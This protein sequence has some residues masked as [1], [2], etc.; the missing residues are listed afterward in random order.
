MDDQAFLASMRTL[1]RS[2]PY[3]SSPSLQ[4]LSTLQQQQ[5]LGKQQGS[6]P[7]SAASVV[8]STG[9]L[10]ADAAAENA[11]ATAA[12]DKAAYKRAATTG[13][14]GQHGS[15]GVAWADDSLGPSDD[16]QLSRLRPASSNSF[17]QGWALR[18]FGSMWGGHSASQP[19]L[20]QQHRRN[21]SSGALK[22][23]I[24]WADLAGGQQAGNDATDVA[25]SGDYSQAPG[26]QHGQQQ[27]QPAVWDQAAPVTAAQLGLLVGRAKAILP[28]ARLEPQWLRPR[29]FVEFDADAW[30]GLL[31]DAELLLVRWAAAAAAAAAAQALQLELCQLLM[32]TC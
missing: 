6:Y 14:L 15:R 12:G 24:S 11:A 30:A 1:S 2:R 28:A 31:E 26:S 32:N 4:K 8:S 13:S 25:N 16:R 22:G 7:K 21:R 17:L 19:Q 5:Q 9:S 29:G 18:S 10:L 3:G 23:S 27:Q 20:Q